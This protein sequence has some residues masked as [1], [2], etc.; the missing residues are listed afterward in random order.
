MK[1]VCSHNTTA[2]YNVS[3][4]HKKISACRQR[5][6]EMIHTHYLLL[7]NTL[8]RSITFSSPTIRTLS[9]LANS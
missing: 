9:S 6:F 1:V 7:I 3:S 5:F 2:A 8:N 4:R